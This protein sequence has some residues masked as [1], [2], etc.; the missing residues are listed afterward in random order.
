MKAESVA[1]FFRGKE[2]QVE[3]YKVRFKQ[4]ETM[5]K[6]T[7]ETTDLLLGVSIYRLSGAYILATNILINNI[8]KLTVEDLY[9]EISNQIQETLGDQTKTDIALSRYFKEVE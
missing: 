4:A 6:L 9:T 7:R 1:R 5:S 3:G 8:E 2:L